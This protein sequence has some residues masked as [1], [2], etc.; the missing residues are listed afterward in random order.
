[1]VEMGYVGEGIGKKDGK[2][3]YNLAKYY[4]KKKFPRDHKWYTNLAV[5]ACSDQELIM[6]QAPTHHFTKNKIDTTFK[7]FNEISLLKNGI[8]WTKL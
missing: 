7:L 3:I 5:I 4:H 6:W 1:M 2:E 8:T